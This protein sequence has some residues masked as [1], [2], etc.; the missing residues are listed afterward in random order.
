MR[1]R[2][3]C[4]LF[5]TNIFTLIELLV[6]ISII[7]I[8]ASMLLPA[9]N[10]A[11]ARAHQS[12]C[13][14]QLKQQGLAMSFYLGDFDEY[15]TPNWD[16]KYCWMQLLAPYLSL[17]S[18][19]M[20]VLRE[21][22]IFTCNSARSPV[23]NY[24]DYGINCLTGYGITWSTAYSVKMSNISESSATIVLGDRE[25]KEGTDINNVNDLTYR[26][27]RKANYLFADGHVADYMIFTL[28]GRFWY[29]DKSKCS[30][31][32]DY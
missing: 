16:G 3:S 29:T 32:A 10:K 23:G 30:S 26:H 7:A 22:K 19:S 8:L 1:T 12:S 20:S 15:Y 25:S 13:A 4:K 21:A 14:N 28:T 31:S 6:V 5:V 11:R 17:K 24:I 9:L 27:N 18:T 2:K